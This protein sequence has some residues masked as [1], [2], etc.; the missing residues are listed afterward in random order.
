M[1]ITNLNN[2]HLDNAKLTSILDAI[3]VL[4]TELA[5]FNFNLSPDDRK[6]YGSIHEQN[7][8]L[9]NKVYDYNK[10]QP[11]L[12]VT[13]VDW[14]EFEN[15]YQSRKNM[16]GIISRLT[17][18]IVKV[19]DAKILHDYDNYQ[20]ALEDYGFTSYKAGGS[21]PGFQTKYNDLKQ[22]FG[23]TGKGSK[24]NPETPEQ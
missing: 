5:N 15:D 9:V 4:E 3:T 1:G 13:D 7:K 8:L 20:V 12:S 18:L 10:T 6:R 21:T 23:R 19:E 17:N 16:E 24:S 22:F 11:N 2:V 14:L